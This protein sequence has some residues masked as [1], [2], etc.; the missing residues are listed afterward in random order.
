[1]D[2]TRK[3]T[4]IHLPS[5]LLLCFVA[6]TNAPMMPNLQ[7]IVRLNESGYIMY[8]CR[9]IYYSDSLT[10]LV[11]RSPKGIDL[12]TANACFNAHLS[13]KY[14]RLCIDHDMARYPNG[15]VHLHGRPTSTLNTCTGD[16]I[17]AGLIDSGSIKPASLTFGRSANQWEDA[18]SIGDA[19]PSL[20][21]QACQRPAF[22][23]LPPR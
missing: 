20:E 8:K 15:Q 18:D 5:R 14:H 22:V 7:S 13:L 2:S 3:A 4:Y 9:S 1:M 10:L 11:P 23:N 19:R 6:A 16:T 21:L 12:V 17:D